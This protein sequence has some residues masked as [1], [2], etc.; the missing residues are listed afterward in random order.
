MEVLGDMD[1]NEIRQKYNELNSE[2]KV[3]VSHMEYTDR[4]ILIR[5]AIKDLQ[6]LCNHNNGS[7]D[8]TNTDECPYCGK[9]FRGV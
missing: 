4:V 1:A 8:F 9:K 7:F 5:D 6:R 2:L 3:A